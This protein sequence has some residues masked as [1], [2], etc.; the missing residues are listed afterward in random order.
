MTE[1]CN[2]P[3]RRETSR[4][5][6]AARAQAIGHRHL[7][8]VPVQAR[9]QWF[10]ELTQARIAVLRK[11]ATIAKVVAEHHLSD[12][13]F[14]LFVKFV[15]EQR[16]VGPDKL[17]EMGRVDRTTASRW[18][19]GHSAPNSITQEAV[20]FKIGDVAAQQAGHFD[21]TSVS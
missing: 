16:I 20:L 21:V 12:E 7:Q 11:V 10:D 17:G 18:I 14:Q 6:K 1:V 5:T 4:A 13:N 19:N 8:K 2:M 3:G 15:N 9:P